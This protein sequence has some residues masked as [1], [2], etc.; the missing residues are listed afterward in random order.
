MN[1]LMQCDKTVT[2]SSREIAS[3]TGKQHKDVIRD[4][5]VMRQA[6]EKDGADLRHLVEH[7]DSRG[8]T[9]EFLL[10][11]TLTETL[12]T[13][14]SI[15]LRHRVI[16]HLAELEQRA[17]PPALPQTLPEALRLAAD[18]AEQN[19]RLQVVVSEQA[20]KV[21]ALA[22]LAE[23][24]G[25]MCLTDAAKHLGIQ[26]CRLIEWMRANRWI[27]RRE[28]S[29]RLLAYQ[30]RM[31]AGLLDHKVSVIGRE[32]DGADRLASQ[33]RVT[34]K[35]LAVLAQKINAAPRFASGENVAR[36]E[37]GNHGR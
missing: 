4:V 10:D 34:A 36:T 11:R 6:L 2:M 24:G 33:V 16:V 22:R 14:Y 25:S 28:G 32:D 1:Q 5:R 15:P 20:P 19:N 12:L 7:K 30:P 3:L 18:L 13:G 37:G 21:E 9:A 17:A 8:Y 31:A 29:M 35:G 27:Y 23:A 26:R